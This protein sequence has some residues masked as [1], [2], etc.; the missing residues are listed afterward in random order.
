[1]VVDDRELALEVGT[2]PLAVEGELRE[3][4]QITIPRQIVAA[5]GFHPGDRVLFAVD[6]NDRNLVYMHRLPETYAGTLR[7]VFGTPVEAAT[8]LEEEQG[9]WSE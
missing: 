3:K 4:N 9:A 6:P 5:T 1:M 8:Y 7:G 2:E